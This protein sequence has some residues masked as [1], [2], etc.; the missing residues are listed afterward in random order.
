MNRFIDDEGNY[1]EVAALFN[2]SLEESLNNEEQKKA[3]AETVRR[4]KKNSLDDQIRRASDLNELQR[5]IREQAG[6]S[7]LV[8][9]L[10]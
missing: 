1:K 9:T 10:E 3:F 8:I 7:S 5:L 2:A 4:I 6:L